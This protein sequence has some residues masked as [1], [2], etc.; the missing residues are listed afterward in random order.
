[1]LYFP[2]ESDK[3][4]GENFSV[5]G[6][7]FPLLSGAS[8]SFA[9]FVHII[10]VALYFHKARDGHFINLLTYDMGVG[11]VDFIDSAELVG[12]KSDYGYDCFHIVFFKQGIGVAVVI[13]ISVVKG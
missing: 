7:A 11:G 13:V 9:Y 3:V 12:I 8:A 4:I 10:G 1:M 6:F 2:L 5:L